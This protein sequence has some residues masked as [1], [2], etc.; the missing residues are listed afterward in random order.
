M[1]IQIEHVLFFVCEHRIKEQKGM[2]RS[3]SKSRLTGYDEHD[4][5]FEEFRDR[6]KKVPPIR[7]I[8]FYSGSRWN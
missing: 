8:E 5:K 4:K 7:N 2:L 6:L 3:K 1:K